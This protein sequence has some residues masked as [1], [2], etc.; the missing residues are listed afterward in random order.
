MG[1]EN[2]SKINCREG[3]YRENTAKRNMYTE[4]KSCRDLS[5]THSN[6]EITA[7]T[8]IFFLS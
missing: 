2:T 8:L 7:I 1:R 3:K 4:K 5:R 6:N